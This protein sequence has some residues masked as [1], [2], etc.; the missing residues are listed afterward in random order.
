MPA[1]LLR[2]I[3]PGEPAI[4]QYTSTGLSLDGRTWTKETALITQ[5]YTTE[6]DEKTR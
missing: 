2:K 5:G 6:E 1:R 4:P 3:P